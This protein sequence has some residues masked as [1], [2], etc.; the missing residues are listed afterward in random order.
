MAPSDMRTEQSRS[1]SPAAMRR[2]TEVG[3]AST[4]FCVR[5]G[6]DSSNTSRL[7]T[8]EFSPSCSAASITGSES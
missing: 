5:I 2:S 1:F 3:I 8:L 7:T 6:A 4:V